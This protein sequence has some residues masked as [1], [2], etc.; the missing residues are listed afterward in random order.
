M[1][2]YLLKYAS[3]ISVAKR[4]GGTQFRS[5]P[6]LFVSEMTHMRETVKMHICVGILVNTVA[7]GLG[8]GKLSRK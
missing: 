2:H 8:E 4:G 3:L 6:R 5:S 1:R 7:Y